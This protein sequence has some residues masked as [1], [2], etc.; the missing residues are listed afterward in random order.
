M[1]HSCE[2]LRHRS[3]H[4]FAMTMVLRRMV[5]LAMWRRGRHLEGTENARRGE[6]SSRRSFT[7]QAPLRHR[8]QMTTT[9]SKQL[10]RNERHQCLGSLGHRRR[11]Q[12]RRRKRCQAQVQARHRHMRHSM[13][14]IGPRGGRSSSCTSSRSCLRGCQTRTSRKRCSLMR[15]AWRRSRLGNINIHNAT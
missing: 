2:A 1:C 9:S 8:S 11:S 15:Q 4:E 13:W 6:R 7:L 14:E 5:P 3:R 12:L 10:A